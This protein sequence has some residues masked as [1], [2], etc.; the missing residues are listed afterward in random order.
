[1]FTEEDVKF[2]LA[3]LALALDYLHRHGIVYRDLKPENILLHQDGHI[4]LT[5]FGLSK[6]AISE[7]SDGRTYSFCGTVEYM[8]PEVVNRH[9]HGTAADWW[10]FGVLMYELLTGTLPFQADHRKDTMELILKAKLAMPQFLSP[11]AQSLLRAL[12]KRTPSNRLGYGPNGFADL[13]K[14]SFFATVN[15]N[16]L[17]TGRATP[18]FKPTCSH[19]DEAVNFDS[20]FTSIPPFDSPGAPPSASAHTLFRGFSYVAPS[21]FVE[22]DSNTVNSGQPA[23]LLKERNGRCSPE[24]AVPE[25]DSSSAT[26]IGRAHPA[27]VPADLPPLTPTTAKH[28]QRLAGLQ[29][30][31]TKQF[32]TDYTISDELGR[33][34]YAIVYK[35]IHRTSRKIFSV[36][37]IDKVKR[38]VREEVEILMRLHSH[39]N[40][41]R[42]W[43]VYEIGNLVYLVM[44]YLEGGELL[45]RI[46]QQKC[47]SEREASAVM[48][49][50]SKTL[51]YLH[52]NMIVHRDLKPSNILYADRTLDPS[53]LRI[54]DFGFAKQLRAE[55]GLLMT[56]CYTA[57]FAAPEV[58]K[59][60]GYHAA[61]D[62]WSLGVLMYTMLSGQAPFASN[63]DDKPD[64]ILSR[65][66]SGK[67]KLDGPIWDTISESAKDL[68]SRMLNPEPSKRCTAEEVVRHSWITHGTNLSPDSTVHV[69]ARDARIIKDN[70]A[71]TFRAIK[72]TPM[73]TLE[74]VES[75]TLARRRGR[76]K[77][78]SSQS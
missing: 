25:V 56:P 69:D 59:M 10:S 8:A 70:V 54:C 52:Q 1:M 3:E 11:D 7:A 71:A 34:S 51:E 13:K 46:C 29:G 18:P 48:A 21:F 72:T 28:F 15:W 67:L 45:D 78:V 26:E 65:I 41:V 36:K 37:V 50:L 22:S 20:Q 61:C 68:L 23:D 39:P 62:V 32:N 6:E 5:D 30:V 44:D 40:I 47:F 31:K 63:P 60:Q 76:S 74:P 16:D 66:E 33:G 42:L 58:L 9:G 77:N 53:S 14:H 19:L 75:S 35:C 49:V 17:L 4:R 2:Y 24:P 38:D 55:N 27:L 73:P 43:D 64:V 57:N 12:F